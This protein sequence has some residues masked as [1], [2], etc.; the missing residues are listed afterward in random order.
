MLTFKDFI[1]FSAL[2]LMFEYENMV[3]I[4]TQTESKKDDEEKHKNFQIDN[5]KK[6]PK[7]LDYYL[8]ENSTGMLI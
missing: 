8:L 4:N 1:I 2:S 7:F 6:L 5:T 3:E